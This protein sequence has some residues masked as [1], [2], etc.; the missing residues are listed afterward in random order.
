MSMSV[1]GKGGGP[2]S[3]INMTPM[4]DI[5]LVLLII[6][7]VVQQGLQKGIAVQVPPIQES[8]IASTEDQIVLTIDKGN[9]YA[10]NQQPIPADGLVEGL[11]KIYEGRNRKVIFVKGAEDITYG[12]VIYAVDAAR[13]AGIEVVGLVPRT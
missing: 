3:E 5:L 13:A 7:M 10:V 4:I 9:V 2:N 1:G 11:K 6:F 12:D 8:D